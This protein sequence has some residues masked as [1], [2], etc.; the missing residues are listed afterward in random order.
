MNEALLLLLEKKDLEFIT[1]TE[2][3]K[4]AGV[5]R[6]TFYLHYDDIYGLLEETIDNLNKQ[7]VSSFKV[8]TPFEIKSKKDAYLI[9]DEQLI[10]YLQFV[11]QNKRVLKLINKKPHLFQSKNVYR[12]MYDNI[13]YPAI[14]HFVED[15]AEKI[16]SLEFFTSGTVAII[17]KWLELDCVTEIEDLVKIIK[18]CIRYENF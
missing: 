2:I 13:F 14:S 5:N 6:S 10:P 18:K 7:F 12:K 9:T 3:T 8:K 4:K 15:E 16:Y 17:H 11:K 1:V